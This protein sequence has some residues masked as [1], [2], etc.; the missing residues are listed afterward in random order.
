MMWPII[1]TQLSSFNILQLKVP[2]QQGVQVVFHWVIVRAWRLERPGCR[3]F[4]Q[5]FAQLTI[6]EPLFNH[7]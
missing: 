2:I 6:N 1:N 4:S 5:I 3:T 7:G